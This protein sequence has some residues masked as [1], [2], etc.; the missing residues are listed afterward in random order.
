MRV[1]L[2]PERKG[3]NCLA[4]QRVSDVL[5]SRLLW[6]GEGRGRGVFYSI[7][8]TFSFPHLG[9]NVMTVYVLKGNDLLKYYGILPQRGERERERKDRGRGRI[10]RFL[11]M[12]SNFTLQNLHCIWNHKHRILTVLVKVKLICRFDFH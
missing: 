1:V 12:A 6:V 10:N 3:G 8:K 11:P 5:F 9:S 2:N 7:A 4:A